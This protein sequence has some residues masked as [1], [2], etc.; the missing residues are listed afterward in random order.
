MLRAGRASAKL[1]LALELTG[2]RSDR[3]HQLVA[4]SQT[5]DWSDLIA[6]ELAEGDSPMTAPAALLE[7]FGPEAGRVPQGPANL[8]LRAANL[9]RA[10]GHGAPI[11][12]L[13]LDKRIPTQSGL[14]GGSAD[15]ATVLRLAG[16]GLSRDTLE[17]LALECGADVPFSLR[18]GA[19]LLHGVGEVMTPLPPLTSGA[20]LIVLLGSV[21]TAAAYRATR[22]GDF[23]D[24]GRASALAEALQAGA[25]PNPRLFGSGLQPAAERV[26]PALGERLRALRAATPGV[27]WAMTGSGGAFFTYQPDPK[28]AVALARRAA[29]SC[30][31]CT[32][33]VA[34]PSPPESA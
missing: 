11:V 29:R 19:S 8:A 28:A 22:T 15:A 16:E 34:L 2:R 6:V 13:A 7:L 24:G 30:P 5:I 10:E 26:L 21:A 32:V 27:G 31:D 33:R 1:N 17:R 3:Y 14:G 25:P 4:V 20:F 12:R 9:L 18:G 23:T